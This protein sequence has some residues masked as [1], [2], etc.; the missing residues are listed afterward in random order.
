MQPALQY[1]LRGL[2]KV[3]RQLDK[4]PS[5]QTKNMPWF[6]FAEPP[7]GQQVDEWVG[8]RV[9]LTPTPETPKQRGKSL[10][11]RSKV[12][13]VRLRGEEHRALSG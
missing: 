6:G 2:C 1:D 10:S 13:G 9:C 8:Q 5:M 11:V 3:A 7:V 4:E 12:R